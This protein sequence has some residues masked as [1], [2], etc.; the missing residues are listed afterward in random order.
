[1]SEQDDIPENPIKKEDI[2]NLLA[3]AWEE[4]RTGEKWQAAFLYR[5]ALQS[6]AVFRDH[7]P[8]SDFDILNRFHPSFFF[9]FIP[10]L[11]CL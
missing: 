9:A 8:R 10:S 11:S 5:R 4:E 7:S 1:M 3:Q 2:D 6:L